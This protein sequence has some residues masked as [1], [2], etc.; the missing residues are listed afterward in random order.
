MSLLIP[1]ASYINTAALS[2]AG[3]PQVIGH[4]LII[5]RSTFASSSPNT[6][7]HESRINIRIGPVDATQIQLGYC[8]WFDQES[9]G[10]GEANLTTTGTLS[11]ALEITSPVALAIPARFGGSL[12]APLNAGETL[13]LTDPIPVTL[14]ANT[15]YWAQ[16]GYKVLSAGD[17]IPIGERGYSTASGR[18]DAGFRSSGAA[19]QVGTAG[20]W[21]TP[22]GGSSSTD[23]FGPSLII[24]IPKKPTVA[25]M[26]FGDSII[27]GQGDVTDTFGNIGYVARAVGNM[28]ASH[29]VVPYHYICRAG[30]RLSYEAYN[31]SY[32]KRR[33]FQYFTH[34]ICNLGV[35]DISNATS[36][37][38][39]QGL[40]LALWKE[41]KDAGL[42]VTQMLITVKNSSSDSWATLANQTFT[43]G[44]VPFQPGGIRDQVNAWILTQVGLGLLDQVV[45]PNPYLLD[46]A[47][48]K[49]LV[50]GAANYATTDG[51]HPTTAFHQAVATNASLPWA[52]RLTVGALV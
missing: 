18:V 20:T 29:N 4:R 28:D 3:K 6:L 43:G 5:P 33:F 14:S 40:Y 16:S 30:N 24:G 47:T 50:N 25:V 1:P 27:S 34:V 52:Q 8:G 26:L 15:S 2:R 38:T 12:T 45:D 36:L 49:W 51:T 35:N 11:S 19:T 9:G 22:S 17:V 44:N 37:A 32:R 21:A 13:L 10:T 31:P 48:N 46:P 42:N 23:G 7:Q 41:F 39:M